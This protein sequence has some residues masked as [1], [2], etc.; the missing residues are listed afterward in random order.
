MAAVTSG[1]NDDVPRKRKKTVITLQTKL[2]RVD[3]VKKGSRKG[4]FVEKYSIAKSIIG[5]IWK[6]HQR[7]IQDSFS[8]TESPAVAKKRCII[9]EPRFELV[10]S[11]CWQW[12]ASSSSAYV[13]SLAPR[14]GAL[15]LFQGHCSS[16]ETGITETS[17][18]YFFLHKIIVYSVHPRGEY[19]QGCVCIQLFS[20]R[21]RCEWGEDGHSMPSKR[22]WGRK[23][24]SFRR[25]CRNGSTRL[26]CVATMQKWQSGAI[27]WSR[28]QNG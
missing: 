26:L 13:Q 6:D 3:K 27:F 17:N 10:D 9:R 25:L 1:S 15:L 11:V 24:S 20:I 7:L 19:W 18:N 14:K 8:S 23:G 12:F 16:Y 5:D 2:K 28:Q 22:G 4:C 21:W